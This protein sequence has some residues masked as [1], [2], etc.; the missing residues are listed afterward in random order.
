MELRHQVGEMLLLVNLI[1][2]SLY[3]SSYTSGLNR[4][5]CFLKVRVTLGQH[6]IVR[7]F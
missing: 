5:R 1:A 6:V 4:S 2:S 3:A 7:F